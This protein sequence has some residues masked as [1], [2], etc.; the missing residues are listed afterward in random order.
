MWILSYIEDT[1]C[2]IEALCNIEDALC[3]I[4]DTLCDIE[5]TV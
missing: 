4:E 2:D 3:V 5:D 1:V